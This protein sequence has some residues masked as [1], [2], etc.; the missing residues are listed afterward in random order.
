[1]CVYVGS[2]GS[3]KNKT[4]QQINTEADKTLAKPILGGKNQ[5]R[6]NGE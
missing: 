2:G 4:Q 3:H 5:K 6:Q 1:M